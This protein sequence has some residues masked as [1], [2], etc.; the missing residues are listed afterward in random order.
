MAGFSFF[1][2]FALI[3]NIF[4]LI[5]LLVNLFVVVEQAEK[6]GFF[7]DT[8]IAMGMVLAPILN[9][10]VNLWFIVLLLS[11]KQITVAKWLTA[12]NFLV[13]ILQ[14]IYFLN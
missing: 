14:I 5:C 6:L 1:S 10:G 2:R 8:A 7:A 11:K 12:F 9:M 3:C 13:L 4:F